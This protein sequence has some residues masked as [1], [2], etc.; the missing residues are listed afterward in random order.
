MSI[1]V[2]GISKKFGNQFA[3]NDLSFSAKPGEVVGFLGPNGAGKSTTMKMLCCYLSP[4]EGTAEVAGFDILK[5]PLDVKKNIG[6]LPE[7]NPLYEDMYVKEFLEFVCAIH[8]IDQPLKRIKE[9]IETTGLEKEQHK[10][11]GT[12]SKGYKQRIGIAQA[13]MHDPKVL[14]LDEPTS[15]LDMNQLVGIREL[16]LEM[17]KEKTVIFSSHI[18][19]E[20]QA[21]CH[22][23]LIINDG[24]L[25]AD[26]PIEKLKSKMAGDLK[27]VVDFE[28]DQA[29]PKQF[30]GIAGVKKIIKEGRK[31]FFYTQQNENIKAEIFKKAV[32]AGL[33]II[34]MKSESVNMESIFRQ[35]TKSQEL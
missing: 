34:E 23:V 9:V 8:K 5:N 12:L 11:I 28:N 15:G 30:E 6:Y 25:V 29:S 14:I 7:H 27:I 18:M 4:S 13:I 31:L 1:I 26:D 2:K 22:R 3:V 33:T 17:G 10:I 21:L 32:A 24:I 16:I 35:L 19:Q 20:V